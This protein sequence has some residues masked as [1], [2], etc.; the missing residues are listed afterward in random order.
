MPLEHLTFSLRD[1]CSGLEALVGAQARA[2]GLALRLVPGA[3]LPDALVGDPTRVRQILLNLIANAIKFTE[4]GEVA[5]SIEPLAAE[6][7]TCR[8]R[9]SV[10]DTG[11][12]IAPEEVERLFLPFAQLDASTT[13]RFGGTGLG[14]SIVRNLVDMLGGSIVARS[15]P[16]RGSCFTLELPFDAGDPQALAPSLRRGEQA[17]RLV[18]VR[19]LLVDDSEINLT[20]AGRLLELEGR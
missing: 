16:G 15:T 17:R 19:V 14:L 18:E 12:G 13:R 3:D 6:P 4:H 7:G 1:L 8:L 10:T 9:F 5:L 2:K 11:I 20:V